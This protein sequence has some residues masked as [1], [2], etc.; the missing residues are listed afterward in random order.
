MLNM[1]TGFFGGAFDPFH[2]EHKALIVHAKEQ[3]GLDKVVVYP[4][5]LPPHKKCSGEFDG[6]FAAAVAG[7]ADLDYVTVDDI[8]GKNN[9][10]NPTY[11]TLP[12]FKEKYPSDEYYFIIGG[13]SMRNFSTWLKPEEVARQAII[14]VAGR[15][16]KDIDEAIAHAKTAYNAD[17]RKI[18]YVG[19]EVSG[20]I[21]RAKLEMLSYAD[22]LSPEV[23]E[24]IKKRGMYHRFADIVETLSSDIPEKTFKHAKRTVLYAMK[25]NESLKLDF[26]K[27]FLASLLHDCAKHIKVDMDGV[28]APVT[29]QYTGAERAREKYGIT[30]EEILNAIRFHTSGKPDM[31]TL[32][33]LVFCADMLEEGRAYEGVEGLR[34]IIEKDFEKGFVACVT[35]SMKKLV[36]DGNPFYYLTKDCYLYYTD[37]DLRL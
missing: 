6:R 34:N 13:D 26:D 19:K 17:V 30:D 37:N 8:E 24:V 12:K 33:K 9:E 22:E 25:L 14:L 35:S 4:S 18:D 15:A 7:T 29:H 23:Y 31:T 1:K 16:D 11:K 28:P 10:Q 36:A 5:Y 3:F 32:E 27:V 20:T 21:I 2:S